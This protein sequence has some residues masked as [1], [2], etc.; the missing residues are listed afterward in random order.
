MSFFCF[1]FIGKTHSNLGCVF[2]CWQFEGRGVIGHGSMIIYCK[3]LV[4]IQS[5]LWRLRELAAEI[6]NQIL[7]WRVRKASNWST[8]LWKMGWPFDGC[9]Q[10][11]AACGPESKGSGLA[12]YHLE[13]SVNTLDV[14]QLRLVEEI[15]KAANRNNIQAS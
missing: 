2:F 10:G 4:V 11:M 1:H 6:V 15:L 13:R 5:N 14:A 9:D 7:T 12:Q 3:T 8:R